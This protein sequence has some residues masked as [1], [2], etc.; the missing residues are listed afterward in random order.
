MSSHAGFDRLSYPGDA[1]MQ[2]LFDQ[3]NLSWTGFYL[4]PSPSQQ[5][6][7]WMAKRDLLK[8]MGWGFAPIYVGQQQPEPNSPGSHIITSE[9][10]RNDASDAA[11]LAVQAGFSQNSVLYLDIE[12][13]GPIHHGLLEYYK[14]W[15]Q[16]VFDNGY[17]PG[18][19]CSYRLASQ[20]T[21]ADARPLTWVFHLKFPSGNG[22]YFP[23]Y[24]DPFPN[25]APSDSGCESATVWQLAQ[26]CSIISGDDTITP[27]DLNSSISLDPST[28]L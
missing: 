10:G 16:G 1:V 9:Q 28:F 6:T 17:Y 13:G 26:H 3:T 4:A 21:N 27:V 25:S 20:L 7:S 12:T 19:Y 22:Q 24:S 11:N 18:V 2:R 23:S 8:A 5:N 14:A 15:V